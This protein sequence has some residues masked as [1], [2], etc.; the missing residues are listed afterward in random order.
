MIKS[1]NDYVSAL[2]SRGN[3]GIFPYGVHWEG[4]FIDAIYDSYG[5]LHIEAETK[6][7]PFTR[8][9]FQMHFLEWKCINFD[10]DFTEVCS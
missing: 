6:W 5:L 10:Y 4:Y 3:D 7:L 1:L 8:L 9:Q 2:F